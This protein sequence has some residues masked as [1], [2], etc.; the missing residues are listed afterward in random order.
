MPKS[1]FS[2]EFMRRSFDEAAAMVTT[3]PNIDFYGLQFHIGSQILEVADIIKLECEKVNDIVSRFES[4]GV[5]IRN[6]D[7]GGGL[8]I[9]YDDPDS[10]PIADF[11]TWFMTIHN[12]LWTEPSSCFGWK[13][14]PTK[15]SPTSSDS[16]PKTSACD[17]PAS[18][19]NSNK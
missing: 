4:N 14:S 6:I 1:R 11:E 3:D 7:L 9:D 17:S 19:C 8:G 5:M 15:K 16:R 18:D 2:D 12:N 13:A 10:N